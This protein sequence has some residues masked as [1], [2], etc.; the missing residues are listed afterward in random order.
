MDKLQPLIN[1]SLQLLFIG[2]GTVFIILISLIFLITLS[3]KLLA[4]F[5]DQSPDSFSRGAA[6]ANKRQPA[7]TNDNELVAV[8]SAA[9]TKYRDQH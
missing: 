5:E 1:E 3:S 8:I 2:M 4:R 7:S 9:I 6:Q